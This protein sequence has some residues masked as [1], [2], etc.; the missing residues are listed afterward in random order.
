MFGSTRTRDV[1][2]I[3]GPVLDVEAALGT[4][5]LREGELAGTFFVIR[6]G[7]AELWR[8]QRKLRTLRPG[9]CFGETDPVDA[10]PQRFTVVAGQQLRLLAFS[11]F[12]IVRLCAT[13][14]GIGERIQAALARSSSGATAAA[15]LEG[16]PIE[17]GDRAV[18]GRDPAQ[19]TH[20]P[21]RARDGLPSRTRPPRKLVL[22]QR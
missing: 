1:R 22:S 6:S 2:S 15:R 20:Q 13:L 9:D 14:P 4:K 10:R 21:Q 7:D 12:G 8:G 3:A 19:L 18:I 16:G 17:D 5:L 11:A